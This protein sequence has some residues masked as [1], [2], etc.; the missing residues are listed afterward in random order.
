MKAGKLPASK[1]SSLS[2]SDGVK[3]RRQ[4]CKGVIPQ[5]PTLQP[6]EDPMKTGFCGSI[7]CSQSRQDTASDVTDVLTNTRAY[8]DQLL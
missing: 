1:F 3:E 4:C 7:T 6:T 2:S 8:A 5:A